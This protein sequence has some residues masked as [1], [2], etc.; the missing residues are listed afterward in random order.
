MGRGYALVELDDSDQAEELVQVEKITI[1]KRMVTI[2]MW[3]REM[4]INSI[5]Y[6]RTLKSEDFKEF[7]NM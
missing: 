2:E 7:L 5:V 1:K 4:K 6:D 3:K